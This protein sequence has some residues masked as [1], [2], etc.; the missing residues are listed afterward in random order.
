[1]RSHENHLNPF[2]EVV[3]NEM[4]EKN[5]I[6]QKKEHT[7]RSYHIA[8]SFQ[9]E[10]LIETLQ[11]ISLFGE[12]SISRHSCSARVVR[13]AEIVT[14]NQSHFIAVYNVC[15]IYFIINFNNN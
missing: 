13:Q 14:I 5:K 15:I 8:I 6:K 7:N 4:C 12:L 2:T 9:N 3:E 1:M 10:R 11:P